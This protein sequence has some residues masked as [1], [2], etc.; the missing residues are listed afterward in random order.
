[1]HITGGCHCGNITY[2]AEIDLETVGICHCSD[3]QKLS[4]SAFRTVVPV[5]AENFHLRGTPTIYVKTAESGNKRA[6]AFCPKC[7]SALYAGAV[8]N[9]PV[10]SL[11]VGTCDQRAELVP[12]RQIWHRSAL[13]WLSKLDIG[14]VIEQQS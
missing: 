9:S 12:K 13:P 7:G 8:E 3:C 1:M 11:R 10:Y 4:C 2:E 5:K 6:Q 14:K